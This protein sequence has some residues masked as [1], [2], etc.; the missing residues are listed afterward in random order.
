MYLFSLFSLQL[1]PPLEGK[2]LITTYTEEAFRPGAEAI[3]YTADPIELPLHKDDSSDVDGF[4]KDA[5]ETFAN[6]LKFM[7]DRKKKINL[8]DKDL[9]EV[10]QSV[11][12][13][14]IKR[15]R[16]RNEVLCQLIKQTT[17]HPVP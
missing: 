2:F 8:T 4:R 6:V 5:V 12:Q 13:K 15:P 9:V 1:T 10:A 16:L 17:N 7:G 11:V 3:F 14:A